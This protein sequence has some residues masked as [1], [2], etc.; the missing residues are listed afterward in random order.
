MGELYNATKARNVNPKLSK[1]SK[2]CISDFMGLTKLDVFV[3]KSLQKKAIEEHAKLKIKYELML[4]DNDIIAL[5]GLLMA[6]TL[7]IK[8]I[9][10]DLFAGRHKR[11][12]SQPSARHNK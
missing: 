8:N 1:I 11:M 10:N 3:C 2:S 12:A 9:I 6:N 7:A 5:R 4:R